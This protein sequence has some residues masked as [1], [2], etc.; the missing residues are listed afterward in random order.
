VEFKLVFHKR[1]ILLIVLNNIDELH[2]PH[3]SEFEHVV[4]YDIVVDM[5]GCSTP[6]RE[7]EL[8][9]TSFDHP[10]Q[11][12]VPYHHPHHKNRRNA[13]HAFISL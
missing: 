9:P 2:V 6:I 13:I 4:T 12:Y 1:N 3:M 8:E 11:K 10:T 7:P 5:L